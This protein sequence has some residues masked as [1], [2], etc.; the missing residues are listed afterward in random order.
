MLDHA[1]DSCTGGGKILSGVEVRRILSHI[2]SDSCGHCKTKVG[3]D[4]DLADCVLG[5]LAELALGDTDSVIHLAAVP[6]DLL[7]KLGD[8]GGSAVKDDGESGELLLDFLKDV[9]AELGILTGLKLICAVAGA[10]S[11]SK[12]V[13]A[14]AADEIADFLGLGVRGILVGDLN[15]ILDAGKSAELALDYNA[16]I[17]SVVNDL[18]GESDVLFIRKM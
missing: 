2:L 1:F 8:D 4:V 6:V 7:N 9:D 13:N 5:C 15:V 10:D 16:V 17:V 12:G 3:V 11:D 14:G 18:L